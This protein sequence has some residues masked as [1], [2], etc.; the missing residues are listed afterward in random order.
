M[1]VCVCVCVAK[2]GWFCTGDQHESLDALSQ[3]WISPGTL[4]QQVHRRCR[5][6]VSSM[7]TARRGSLSLSLSFSLCTT[8]PPILR[9][10][11][12]E[13]R[14]ASSPFG[15]PSRGGSPRSFISDRFR[16]VNFAAPWNDGNATTIG[17]ERCWQ[18]E[19][20]VR[21]VEFVVW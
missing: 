18:V 12:A 17:S 1:C 4:L 5:L 13:L 15:K 20:A 10:R 21:R 7:Q 11:N 6:A 19:F 16:E 3:R 9:L 8:V 2:R 14:A